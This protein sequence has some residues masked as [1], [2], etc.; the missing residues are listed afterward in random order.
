M[1]DVGGSTALS[2]IDIALDDEATGSLPESDPITA[3]TYK[4]TQGALGGRP[5]PA[6]FLS[7]APVGPYGTQLSVFDGTDP[8]G[9]WNLYV[10]DDTPEDADTSTDGRWR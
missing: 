3:G 1:S 5:V 10:M 9:T 2:G 4:P 7:P 8:N 6:N